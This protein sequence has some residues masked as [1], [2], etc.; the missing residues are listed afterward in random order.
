VRYSGSIPVDA[1][2]YIPELTDNRADSSS[3]GANTE[4]KKPIPI[5]TNSEA[6]GFIREAL[7]RELGNAGW[8]V[9]D[10]PSHAT[11]RLELRLVRF[12]AEESL[13]Y[14]AE[15]T[16]RARLV[17]RG[18]AVKWEGVLGGTSSRWG[19]SLTVENYQEAFSDSVISLVESLMGNPAFLNA[20]KTS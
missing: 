8:A 14:H 9:V 6:T 10:S 20:F 3:V 11:H 17:D 2:V 13:A 19:R 16:L 4:G 1:R 12:W 18:G 7:N 5:R 15:L